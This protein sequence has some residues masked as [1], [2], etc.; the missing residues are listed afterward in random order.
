MPRDDRTFITLHD[1]MPE[2]PKVEALSDAAF[3]LLIE[4]WCWC[5]RNETDGLVAAASWRKRGSER[6]RQELLD[7]GLAC[8][9]DNGDV[10]MHDYLE[11]QRSS[12]EIRELR[13]KRRA[14]GKAGGKAK[15]SALANGKQAASKALASARAN[16]KQVPSKPLASA[17]ANGKQND[18]KPL[19]ETDTDTELLE[20]SSSSLKNSG[21]TRS[22]ED[23]AKIT[24]L[25]P[26]DPVFEALAQACGIA[27]AE[28]TPSLRGAANRARKELLDLDPDLVP[29]EVLAR[30]RRYRE[31]FPN[32]ALTPS[33]LA[34]HWATLGRP[35]V[36]PPT[37]R[38]ALPE[39]W[40]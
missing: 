9:Q 16:A 4:T 3:R 19:A 25:R 37:G 10:Q 36:G 13:E 5:S 24:D 20:T 26:R 31:R 17:L 40:L 1:G 28:L 30:G 39:A 38:A 14:A 34:K 29:D 2:N 7:A 32:A 12:A 27:L 21:A 18:S 11:H 33:A 22:R 8:E 35:A 6:S 23:G 15:A